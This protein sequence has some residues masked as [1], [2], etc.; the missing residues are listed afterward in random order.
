[1]SKQFSYQQRQ[2]YIKR[3]KTE[4]QDVFIIGGG[5]TGAGILLDAT[6]RGLTSALVDMQDFAQG[7]SGRST[8]LIHG[9]LRYLNSIL[10]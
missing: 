7:T 6:T 5:A 2:A 4:E 1:M 10:P 9:G 8:K 3:L